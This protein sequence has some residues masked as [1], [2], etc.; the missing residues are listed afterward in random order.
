[1]TDIVFKVDS[2]HPERMLRRISDALSPPQITYAVR[3]GAKVI[4]QGI[5][6]RAPRR[7]GRLARSFNIVPIDV[8]SYKVESTLIYAPVQEYGATIR[9]RNRTYLRFIAGGR[10]VFTKG[11]VVI[12]PQPYVRPTFDADGQRALDAIADRIIGGMTG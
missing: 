3:E 11:P 12:P 1:M 9:P 2:S 8:Y 10:V 4:Q 7:S 5:A 6:R